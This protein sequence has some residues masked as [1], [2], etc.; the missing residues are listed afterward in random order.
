MAELTAKLFYCADALVSKVKF[1]Q[2]AMYLLTNW[3]PCHELRAAWA[4]ERYEEISGAI[5]P[6]LQVG[7]S[8]GQENDDPFRLTLARELGHDR[9]DV[10]T[11][12]IGARP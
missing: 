9:V 5:A 7:T 3:Y 2:Q 6:I 4:C 11:A 12:Y 1:V 10:V 8:L